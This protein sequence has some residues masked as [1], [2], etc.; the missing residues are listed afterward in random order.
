L[1][2]GPFRQE[3]VAITIEEMAAVIRPEIARHLQRWSWTELRN[4]G[5]DRPHKVEY[6]PFTQATWEANL[7]VLRDFAWQ[8]PTKLRQDCMQ[9]FGLNSGLANVTVTVNPPGAARVQ[10][11]SA[12]HT[13][14]PSSGIYFRDYSLTATAV[15]KPG[16]RFTSWSNGATTTNQPRWDMPLS[17]ANI[18]MTANFE[19]IQTDPVPSPAVIVTEIHY[20]PAAIQ[21]SGDWV[22]L[23]NRG[24][25]SV[26]LT[27]WNFR[28]DND[29]HD[30]ILPAITLA[31]GAYFV[32]CQDREKFRRIYPSVTN[33]IG[34]FVFGLGNGGDTLRLFDPVG[35]FMLNLS[36][37]DESPWPTEADGAGYTLQLIDANSFSANPEAWTISPALGGT[38][39]LINP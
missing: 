10:L 8:R 33:C 36:Y 17:V 4:R 34:N 12:I 24:A 25:Q 39:G 23:H 30:F 28:D 18:A 31:P 14:F 21:D 29:T 11:N 16:Y 32:L 13:V 5:F 26:S 37:G 15:P 6:Q 3:Q 22:E 27:G 2:N 35:N 38:P 1:L 19:P 9:R 20:H 7:Q